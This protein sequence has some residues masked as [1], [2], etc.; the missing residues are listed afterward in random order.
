MSKQKILALLIFFLP[1][2]SMALSTTSNEGSLEKIRDYVYV[3][4]MGMNFT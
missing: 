4:L 3:K 2:S 1:Y